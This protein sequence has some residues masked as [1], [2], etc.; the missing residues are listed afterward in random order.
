MKP[1][2]SL[3]HCQDEPGAVPVPLSQNNSTKLGMRA[4]K[5]LR[6]SPLGGS[7]PCARCP[8]TFPA[9]GMLVGARHPTSA[10]KSAASNPVPTLPVPCWLFSSALGL[11][12]VW[13]CPW[14]GDER[15]E[16]GAPA[17]TR[18]P[19]RG[20]GSAATGG[21]AAPRASTTCWCL[22]PALEKINKIKNPSVKL[23]KTYKK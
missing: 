18:V 10:P 9:A 4:A 20:A 7:I 12:V 2:P 22:L 15:G 17:G 14:R 21:H 1:P 8:S 5:F 13:Q 23:L 19:E 3:P 6:Q 16:Q 11:S